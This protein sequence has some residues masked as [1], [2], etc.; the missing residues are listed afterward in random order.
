MH[1]CRVQRNVVR[2]V[3]RRELL[4]NMRYAGH[5]HPVTTRMRRSDWVVGGTLLL[6]F[7]GLSA[8]VAWTPR[9]PMLRTMGLPGPSGYAGNRRCGAWYTQTRWGW[10]PSR[11]ATC[12]AL[13]DTS[14]PRDRQQIEYDELTRRV[15][16]VQVTIAPPDSATWRFQFDSIAGAIGRRGGKLILCESSRSPPTIK[17]TRI[18]R[19][20]GY[21]VRLLAYRF[22]ADDARTLEWLLQLDG[23]APRAREC[24]RIARLHN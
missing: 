24:E 20:E 4:Q 18:W 15:S 13:A 6:G 3:C 17:E 1:H 21:D 10:I 2:C 5:N 16:R 11:K 8:W 12:D 7:I 22:G 19:F 23:F 14:R 9:S